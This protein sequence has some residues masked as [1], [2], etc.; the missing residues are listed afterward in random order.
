VYVCEDS[1]LTG[2]FAQGSTLANGTYTVPA[3]G[4]YHINA[5]VS[6][7]TPSA[8][9]TRMA[10]GIYKTNSSTQLDSAGVSYNSGQTAIVAAINTVVKLTRNDTIQIVVN[11]HG[12]SKTWQVDSTST[13]YGKSSYFNICKVN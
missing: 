3:T 5:A 6:M 4:Y 12:G 1:T 10:I 8:N 11:G 9:G 13:M 2:G 7:S